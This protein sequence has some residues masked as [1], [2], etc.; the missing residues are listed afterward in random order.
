MQLLRDRISWL[1]STCSA[2]KSQLPRSAGHGS[3]SGSAVTAAA[4]DTTRSNVVDETVDGAASGTGETPL[5]SLGPDETT[6]EPAMLYDLFDRYP[7]R[8]SVLLLDVRSRSEYAAERLMDRNVVCIDPIILRQGSTSAMLQDALVVSPAHELKLFRSKSLFDL[9]VVY[10]ENSEVETPAMRILLHALY[11]PSEWETPL[12]R[13]PLIL[14][15][16]LAAWRRLLID[17]HKPGEAAFACRVPLS[18]S[19]LSPLHTRRGDDGFIE[20]NEEEE[21][22]WL[23]ALQREREYYDAEQQ[24]SPPVATVAMGSPTLSSSALSLRQ[25]HRKQSIINPSQYDGTYEP[26]TYSAPDETASY[27]GTGEST[28]NSGAGSH[29]GP[30]PDDY[31]R[32]FVDFFQRP[33]SAQRSRGGYGGQSFDSSNAVLPAV[34]PSH[35]MPSPHDPGY[36]PP[37]PANAGPATSSTA[38]AAS[39]AVLEYPRPGSRGDLTYPSPLSEPVRL[40]TA[41]KTPIPAVVMPRVKVG[42]RNLGNTCYMNSVLQCLNAVPELVAY[43]SSRKYTADINTQN[44]LGYKGLLANAWYLLVRALNDARRSAISPDQFRAVIGRVQPR[45]REAEQQDALEFLAFFL[46]GLH[47]DLNM[48]ASRSRLRDLTPEEEAHRER[49]DPQK[50]AQIEWIRYTHR[51]ASLV[52]NEFQGQ[53]ASRLRCRRCGAQSTTY[54]PLGYLSLPLTAATPG[55]VCTLTSCMREF[56]KDEVLRGDDGWHCPQCQRTVEA[57]KTIKI[58]RLPT[59][60]VVHLKRFR[61]RGFSHDKLNVP[62]HFPLR[63]LSV[64][65]CMLPGVAAGTGPEQTYELFGV[66][67]HYG[68]MEGGH[69]KWRV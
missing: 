69:C 42:L 64:E 62:V 1:E 17:T 25:Y 20:I 9:V 11:S 68:T 16:G 15:G 33:A 30:R 8:V 40:G 48:A 41:Q 65:P 12:W 55:G 44:P 28:P 7:G 34:I 49:M 37:A 60:L 23:E 13:R 52:V 24:Q 67:N 58:S 56:S 21:R 31:P 35:Y 63:D 22:L 27:N 19:T 57:D 61:A 66:V 47:E 26:S 39:R 36:P 6:I 43:F 45:F 4:V 14:K 32:N 51:S 46:D 50:V 2:L 54:T 18:S 5:Q 29:Q 59:T 3:G 38:P 10:D 53:Y